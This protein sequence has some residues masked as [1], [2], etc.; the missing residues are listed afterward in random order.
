MWRMVK[1][2][3][4][5]N[6]VKL[7]RLVKLTMHGQDDNSS[8]DRRAAAMNIDFKE[9]CKVTQERLDISQAEL[10]R[11]IGMS[12]ENFSAGLRGA[13]PITAEA[14]IELSE[15]TGEN[16]KQLLIAAK[17]LRTMRGK[18]ADAIMS[19]ALGVLLAVSLFLTPAQETHAA[20]MSYDGH[21]S[22][23]KIIV[24]RR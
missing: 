2:T 9:V 11:R 16:A 5:R 21:V 3:M 20:S 24:T 14:V 12:P 18:A 1:L 8:N 23:V 22:D 15:I 4:S 13:R 19:A 7:I 10:G 17:K 6:M